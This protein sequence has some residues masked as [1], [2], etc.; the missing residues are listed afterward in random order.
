M[1]QRRTMWRTAREP[2]R[3][4]R[5]RVLAGGSVRRVWRTSAA[6]LVL[7]VRCCRMRSRIFFGAAGAVAVAMVFAGC[8][9]APPELEPSPT[10]TAQEP[11]FGSL[12]EAFDAAI[13]AYQRYLDVWNQIAAEGGAAPERLSAVTEDGELLA[14]ERE[15]F[16]GLVEHGLYVTG[17]VVFRNARLMQYDDASALIQMYACSDMS[18]ARLVDGSGIDVTPE[19]DELIPLLLSFNASA[20]DAVELSESE[21]WD[22]AGIC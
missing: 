22:R 2:E 17:E 20:S 16:S 6:E 14:Q 18:N 13:A 9:G 4:A 3:G 19:R 5:P 1:A 11:V 8:G 21:L 7:G 10:R 12:D 15:F